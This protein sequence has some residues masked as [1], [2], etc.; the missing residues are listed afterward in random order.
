MTA[1]P[2]LYA[3]ESTAWFLVY[4]KP[5]QEHMALT[6]LEQQGFEVYLPLYKKSKPSPTGLVPVHEPMFPRYLFV[7]PGRLDQS[8]SSIKI[9]RGVSTL[10]RFG[11][12]PAQVS[13]TLIDA[14]RTMEC[15]RD[16]ALPGT[17]T[18][19]QNGQ[20]VALAHVAMHNMQGLVQ[21]VSS[22][23]VQVLLEIL[24]RPVTVDLEH[25]QVRP[26]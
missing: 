12:E 18:D 3:K 11:I 5:R 2:A 21:A 26:L 15:E 16:Q 9:T 8:L 4:A 20:R 17:L 10:V 14:I 25:H 24:G 13:P 23:R 19:I 7:K 6:Q 1:T 22:K